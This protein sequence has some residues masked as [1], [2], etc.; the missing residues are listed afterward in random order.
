LRDY[1]DL[2]FDGLFLHH[3]GREQGRF[4]DVFGARVLPGVRG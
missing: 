2:G 4:L 1:V 3:V